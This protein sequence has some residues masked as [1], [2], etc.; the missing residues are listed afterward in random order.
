MT[1]ERSLDESI[2]EATM[3]D[4]GTLVLRLR[5][6]T[7]GTIGESVIQYKPGDEYYEYVLRHLEPI[8][9]G[10]KK[11]VPPFPDK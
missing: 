6:E 9:P 8:Q 1:R 2:G 3:L 4:D 11:P 10:Q 5:A 7:G